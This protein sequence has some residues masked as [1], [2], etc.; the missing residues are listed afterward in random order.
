MKIKK[1]D[2]Y[3]FAIFILSLFICFVLLEI[4]LYSDLNI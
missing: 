2:I 1:D 4:N 3:I